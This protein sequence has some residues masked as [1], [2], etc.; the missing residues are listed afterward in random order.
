VQKYY[1]HRD[2]KERLNIDFVVKFYE[3]HD[4]NRLLASWWKEYNKF[5][6]MRN[7][8]YTIVN[9]RDPYM[10][11]M[12]LICRLYGEKDC[13]KFSEAWMPLAYTMEI[14]GRSFNWGAV[15]SNKL[16]INLSQD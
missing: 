4:T 16:S 8:R 5:T 9:L 7:G 13:S 14:S 3:I 6:N 2:S 11:L 10:Y 12:P 1:K 15:I